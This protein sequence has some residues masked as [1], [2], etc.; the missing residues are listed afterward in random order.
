MA[1][2]WVRSK[3]DP[4]SHFSFILTWFI[5]PFAQP[6]WSYV[7]NSM[8]LHRGWINGISQSAISWPC[9]MCVSPAQISHVRMSDQRI[10]TNTHHIPTLSGFISFPFYMESARGSSRRH[11]WCNWWRCLGTARASSTG[12]ATDSSWRSLYFMSYWA[13][14]KLSHVIRLNH[15]GT[16]WIQHESVSIPQV[17]TSAPA[18]SIQFRISSSWCSPSSVS[19]T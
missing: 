18:P 6:S 19:G 13:S 16:F 2:A 14:R 4:L 3:S 17:S 15:I 11:S 10:R 12:F 5:R 7:I 8:Q 9:Y 1:L